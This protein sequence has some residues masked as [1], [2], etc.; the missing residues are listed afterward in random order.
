MD[1]SITIHEAGPVRSV[2]YLK[3]VVRHRR[4]IMLFARRELKARYAQ[5]I[6]GFCWT[7]AQPL[8]WLV[9][10]WIFF[11]FVFKVQTGAIPYPIF[12]FSGLVIWQYF[13]T[14][15]Q[16][17]STVLIESGELITSIYY[18]KLILLLSRILSATFDL[19]IHL[20]IL[21]IMMAVWK[22]APAVTIIAF[23]LAIALA[24]IAGITVG[25]WIS[26]VSIRYRDAQQVMPLLLQGGIWLTPVF[27]E[28]SVVPEYLHWIFYMNPMAGAVTVAR[29]TLLGAEAP[30]LWYLSGT[31]LNIMLLIMGYYV[32]IRSERVIADH[33]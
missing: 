4:L 21:G 6:L 31:M 33:I 14:I 8:F 3:E 32:F 5:T 15:A 19:L 10:F 29:W 22:F 23:P 2:T 28:P 1:P 7:A 12:L 17:T 9:L 25:I 27:F 16:R 11:T 13:I 18:P 20:I 30:Q 26:A 24:A